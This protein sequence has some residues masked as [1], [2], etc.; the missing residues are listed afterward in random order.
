MA[1]NE[2]KIRE[3]YLTLASDYIYNSDD[4]DDM[5]KDIVEKRLTELEKIIGA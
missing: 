5:K 2:S 1:T 4:W 3:R